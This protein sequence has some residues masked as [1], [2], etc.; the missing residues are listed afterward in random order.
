[1][2]I[3]FTEAQEALVRR[4]VESGRLAR[5][6]D[7]VTEALLLW[8]EQQR[9]R[10]ALLDSLAAG[11]EAIAR[12]EG[13]EITRDSMQALAEDVKRRGRERRATAG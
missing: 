6:E 13:T 1:M 3:T 2:R 9:A 8:E 12:G 10:E 4:A 5:A 11:R 7:A